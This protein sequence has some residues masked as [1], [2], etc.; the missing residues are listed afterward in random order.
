MST[1][2]KSKPTKKA[3]AKPAASNTVKAKREK[4]DRAQKPKRVSALDAAAQVLRKAGKTMNCS[5]LITAMAEQRLWKSPG[6]QTPASTLYSAILR[7]ITAKGKNA[8]FKKI[9]RGQFAA[10]GK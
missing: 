8:R 5:V 10:T 4:A 2:E 3:G 9:D 1:T 7:E 6:G